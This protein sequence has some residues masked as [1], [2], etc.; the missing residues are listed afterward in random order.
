MRTSACLPASTIDAQERP[1]VGSRTGRRDVTADGARGAVGLVALLALF[2]GCTKIPAGRSAVDDVTVRGTSALDEDDVE[3]SMST[4]AS[5]K[6]VGLFRGVVYDYEI[7]DRATLQ[8][9]LARIERYYRARGYYGAHARAGRV[10]STGAGHVRVEVMVEEGQP[11][12]N[13]R[14]TVDGMDALSPVT[15]AALQAAA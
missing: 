3:G 10:L 2:G 7:F 1:V 14:L 5:P 8:R 4:E 12:V 9:D 13:R 6:F 15:Q 11:T